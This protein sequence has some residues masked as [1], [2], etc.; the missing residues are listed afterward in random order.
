MSTCTTAPRSLAVRIAHVLLNEEAV[1]VRPNDPFT[2]SS[3]WIAPVYCDNRVL[4][5]APDA[6][7]RI[8]EGFVAYCAEQDDLPR[9]VAGTAT[10]GIPHATLLADRLHTGLAYVRSSA[11]SHGR[12]RQV[13]GRVAATDSVIIVEDLVSTGGSALDAVH[14]V[15]RTGA[16]VQGVLAIF[17]Y[18]FPTAREA[19]ADADCSLHALTTFETLAQVARDTGRLSSAAY[20]DVMRWHRAPSDWTPTTA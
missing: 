10:A 19:F 8:Q 13:E 2:W 20:D 16:S 12:R 15:R 4:L 11:K 6:R 7:A 17:S 14:G 3:G 5:D 18:D 9:V 1:Q